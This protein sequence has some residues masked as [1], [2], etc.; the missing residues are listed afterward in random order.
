MKYSFLQV[1]SWFSWGN[2]LSLFILE[3]VTF[4]VICVI[5]LHFWHYFIQYMTL[6]YKN[7]TMYKEFLDYLTQHIGEILTMQEMEHST[8]IPRKTLYRY[9]IR[10]IQ[11]GYLVQIRHGQYRPKH[12]STS[13]LAKPF[14]ERVPA[15]Y[16]P[17]FLRWY[18]PNVSSFLG[19]EREKIRIATKD[20]TL[21]S[22]LD[23]MSNRR[24]IEI[25]LVDLSYASSHLEGNT[26]DYVDTEILIQYGKSNDMKTRDETT[27][28]LNHKRA[29][30]HVISSRNDFTFSKKDFFDIHT[31]LAR[32]LIHDTYLGI[33][34]TTQVR[35][36][37]S[38]YEP[39]DD[40]L[41]I[42]IEFQLFID[43]LR[44]IHDPFEQSVFILVFIP[45]FQAFIDLNKRTSRLSANIPLIVH[46]YAP[47]SLITV[48]PKIYT[49]AILAIYELNDPSLMARVFA[50]NYVLNMR[51]YM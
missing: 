23:S 42:D 8:Q 12:E 4:S 49:N 15:K 30:E 1:L 9:R 26:Y 3:S 6:S 27:M 35:I 32:W 17:N 7:D 41:M 38:R 46:G 2:L 22:T 40:P 5:L 36:G 47:V 28:I 19:E 33:F 37:G 43:K 20:F 34:R 50:D 13:Y 11:E 31:L 29:I 10:A 39:I 45:Y 18:V 25:F 51:R 21:F 48:E 44:A 16:N 24:A 14:F